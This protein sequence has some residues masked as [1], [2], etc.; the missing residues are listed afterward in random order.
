[1]AYWVSGT[2]QKPPRRVPA[3]R[4]TGESERL[5]ALKSQFEESQSESAHHVHAQAHA[6]ASHAVPAP[7][8]RGSAASLREEGSY[9]TR[10]AQAVLRSPRYVVWPTQETQQ[11]LTDDLGLAPAAALFR[12]RAQA[13]AEAS[14]PRALLAM[15]EVHRASE[16]P[17]RTGRLR[18]GGEA[19]AAAGGEDGDGGERERSRSRSPTFGPPPASP[20]PADAATAAA[21]GVTGDRAR[22]PQRWVT[23]RQIYRLIE[24]RA[25]RLERQRSGGRSPRSRSYSGSPSRSPVR[26]ASGTGEGLGGGGGG[27]AEGGGGEGAGEEG[28]EAA[29]AA[30][31][32]AAAKTGPDPV[33]PRY[34]Q[35]TRSK[36]EGTAVA[37][38]RVEAKMRAMDGVSRRELLA[39]RTEYGAWYLPM[40]KWG[41]HHGAATAVEEQAARDRAPDPMPRFPEVTRR[42]LPADPADRE[43]LARLVEVAGAFSSRLYRRYLEEQRVPLPYYLERIGDRQARLRADCRVFIVGAALLL[44]R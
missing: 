6:R 12:Q 7:A 20:E 30:Q 3:F 40:Q 14:P 44:G 37:R 25:R 22:S 21:A 11:A 4:E 19:A 1:M 13:G 17:A 36:R 23:A 35:P 27:G 32:A 24:R 2:G 31:A 38:E 34:M 28:G 15:G 5:A 29:A 39:R 41:A 42:G 8:A 43:R 16:L 9:T 33:L 10:A 26:G 18:K